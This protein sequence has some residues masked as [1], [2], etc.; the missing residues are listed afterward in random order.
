MVRP[1]CQYISLLMENYIF[2]YV[3][4]PSIE[5]GGIQLR[6][7]VHNGSGGAHWVVVRQ[8]TLPR[9]DTRAG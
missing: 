5:L 8:G 7:R 3:D 6:K 9:R 2:E 4:R 1:V